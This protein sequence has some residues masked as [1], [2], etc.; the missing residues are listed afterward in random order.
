MS[1][2]TQKLLRFIF[3]LR[4]ILAL[5]VLLPTIAGAAGQDQQRAELMRLQQILP[6]SPAFDQWL[7]T[8]GY[9]PPDF[10]S[11]P[12]TPYP[13]DLLTVKRGGKSQQITAADWPER[14][15]ELTR[16]SEE[17]LLGHAPPAPGNVRAIVEEKTQEAD[18]EIWTVRLEFGPEHAAR[19]HCSLWIPRQLRRKPT[20]VYLVDNLRYTQF[21]RDAFDRGDFLICVY[22]ATDPV[23]RPD[24]KD[25][26]EAYKDL[27]GK[28]DWS[29]FRRRG[30]SASRAVDWLCTLDFVARD[31]I[32]IGGHSRSAKQALACAAFDE[33]IA[34]V[35]ASS[36]GAGGSLHFRYS[37]QYYYGESAERLTTAFPLWVSPMVRFFAGRENKLPADM[38]FV[39][40]LIAPR[41]VLMSTAIN[42]SVES[43]WAVEQMFQS[44]A[45]VWQ[46]L[47][48]SGNLA[49]R[50][51][52]GP[53][54]PDA[55]TH[56]AHSAFLMLCSEGKSPAAAFPY[57]PYHPWDYEAWKKL[58]PPPTAPSQRPSTPGQ[59]RLLLQWLLGDGPA[60]E[61]AEVT[62]GEGEPNEIAQLLNRSVPARNKCRFGAINGTFYYPRRDP[63]QGTPAEVE[64]KKQLP[65]IIW[66][67]PLHCSTGYTPG[68]RTGDIPHT[69][70][71]K[72]GF[73]VLAF[74]PIATGARQEERREFYDRH[75]H[76]SLMGKM[77]LD[78]R[79]AIDAALANPDVDPKR[80]SLVGFGMGGMVAAI[81]AAIDERV[82]ACA[83]AS[84][85]TA[86][87]GD[88]DNAGAGG[89]RRWSHLYGW[90]PRLGAFVGDEAAVPVDFQD[91]L[92][93]IAP[94]RMFVVAPALDWHHPQAEVARV[95]QTALSTYIAQGVVDN[96]QIYRPPG[97][98]EFNN[99][100]QDRIVRFLSPSQAALGLPAAEAASRLRR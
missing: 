26:S 89:L 98:A 95:V 44:I 74:D 76:W 51:H 99:D 11:L 79:Q 93:A 46:L 69:R 19:L 5:L 84:G 8:F 12:T 83:S 70:L 31:Q 27:F 29:E 37:D 71:A 50:Y 30:W 41:P 61:P 90:L 24:K 25:Q 39:Y 97:F 47:G 96:L 87:R 81:T 78:A 14:R 10:E 67:A 23:Y 48:K 34:G 66:L 9:L 4:V 88:D 94:R 6:P 75:P 20:P 56:S 13:Q 64:G 18:H 65:T 62:W 100:M 7:E 42:D 1:Q 91:I 82:D 72:A 52:P 16:L 54:R 45:P 86:F 3:V 21:A 59:T 2:P 33:R 36:P 22:N 57:Q 63:V 43:T 80:I 15:K 40:A 35:V 85:F 58:N 60:Y 77:V 38:H 73:L 49:L 55:A 32:Y 92:A 28:F 68:Y 53:H 17:Y